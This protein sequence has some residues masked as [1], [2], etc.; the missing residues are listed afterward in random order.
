MQCSH[1]AKCPQFSLMFVLCQANLRAPVLPERKSRE[2]LKI[3]PHSSVEL[4]TLSPR[5]GA[6]RM[7]FIV[8]DYSSAQDALAAAEKESKHWRAIHRVQSTFEA[9]KDEHLAV[10]R[11]ELVAILR[12][13]SPKWA[14]V[15]RYNATGLVPVD[16]LSEMPVA[17]EV[18]S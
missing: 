9:S 6:K 15:S 4:P 5:A 12:Q 14:L 17:F 3:S 11:D 16:I 7:T 13:S 1:F 8:E 10:Q 2:S 18:S